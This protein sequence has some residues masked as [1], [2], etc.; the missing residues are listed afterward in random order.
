MRTLL[1]AAA[2]AVLAMKPWPVTHDTP[3]PDDH[4]R[5]RTRT[6]PTPI[7]LP[8]AS[9]HD[10]ASEGVFRLSQRY[11]LEIQWKRDFY[12]ERG[13]WTATT[14]APT[15][16]QVATFLPVLKE[17]LAIYPD[18]VFGR[19]KP[20]AKI[21]LGREVRRNHEHFGGLAL[22]GRATL[23]LDTSIATQEELRQAFHHEVYHLLD[24]ITDDAWSKLNA[25]RFEYTALPTTELWRPN[26]MP[27]FLSTYSRTAAVEDRAELFSWLVT[28]PTLVARKTRNDQILR[29]KVAAMKSAL[30]P[31]GLDQT[32][33][34]TRTLAAGR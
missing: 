30:A 10:R 7:P 11:G 12:D 4:P 9:A 27:G 28:Q 34:T 1:L 3:A 32:F 25:E 15:D 5:H 29:G 20:V 14:R 24:P 21:V 19:G 22:V 18:T 33:W 6:A 8:T 31:L 2:T 16:E 13:P 23:L 26:T 17:A